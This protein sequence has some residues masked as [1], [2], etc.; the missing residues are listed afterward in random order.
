MSGHTPGPWRWS[1]D[2]Q[3]RDLTDTWGLLGK[4]GYGILSCDGKCNSPQEANAANARLIAAAPD[5]LAALQSS[6]D[7]LARIALDRNDQELADLALS[8][9]AAARGATE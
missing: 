9:R 7:S 3:S 4:D 2:Y 5:L 6:A 1:D 8:M